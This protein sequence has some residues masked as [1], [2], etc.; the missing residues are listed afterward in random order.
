MHAI[1]ISASTLT[2]CIGGGFLAAVCSRH[3]PDLLR[4]HL[5]LIRNWLWLVAVPC[6]VLIWLHQAPLPSGEAQR[7]GFAILFPG[8]VRL[9]SHRINQPK[10]G[11]KRIVILGASNMAGWAGDYR[12]SLFDYR[13][14]H[15]L[16]GRAS[17]AACMEKEL[18]REGVPSRV[19]NLGVNA[20]NVFAELSLFLYAME[21]QPDMIIHGLVA[22]SFAPCDDTLMP[23]IRNEIRARLATHRYPD[24][25]KLEKT[26]L[27]LLA[28]TDSQTSA[29]PTMNPSR[30]DGIVGHAGGCLMAAYRGIGLPPLV[31]KPQDPMPSAAELT[32]LFNQPAPLYIKERMRLALTTYADVPVIMHRIAQSRGVPYVVVL[33]PDL[34]ACNRPFYEQYGALLRARG[35]TVLDLSQIG[36]QYGTE[37]YDGC[38]STVKGNSITAKKILDALS[39]MK[40]FP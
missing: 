37:T 13:H 2:A 8:Y 24:K 35:L 16:W 10:E 26:I 5:R 3:A 30:W 12:G 17:L 7:N 40:I 18:R 25:D 39:E 31:T 15:D 28:S 38:H 4:A 1:P 29:T 11:Q 34:E 20:G 22:P 36:L 32:E 33:P 14:R 19:E 27:T 9:S 23:E 6:S 21:R